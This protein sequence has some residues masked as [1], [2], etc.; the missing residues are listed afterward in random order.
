MNIMKT[1]TSKFTLALMSITI[2]SLLSASASMSYA[3]TMTSDKTV[4][5]PTARI[6]ISGTVD[7]GDEFYEPVMITVYDQ[8]GNEIIK[9]QS[10]VDDDNHFSELLTGPLGSFDTGVYTIEA[11]HVSSPHIASI[12]I[13]VDELIHDESPLMHLTPLKQIEIGADPSEVVCMDTHMLVENNHRD[14]VACVS[15]STAITLE[16]RGWG[17]LY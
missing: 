11:S 16:A 2:A 4:L 10:L 7:P 17:T 12:V 13:G 5:P 8:S 3:I 9:K 6:F 1:I 14:S 15:P